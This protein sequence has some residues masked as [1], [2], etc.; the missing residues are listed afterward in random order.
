MNKKVILKNIVQAD[1]RGTLLFNEQTKDE[2]TLPAVS[3]AVSFN[4]PKEAAKYEQGEVYE[5]IIK[6]AG[7]K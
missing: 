7:T 6:K 1:K 3:V 4:D 5:V 2:K